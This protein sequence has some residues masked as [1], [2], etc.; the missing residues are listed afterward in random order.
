MSSKDMQ[1][2]TIWSKVVRSSRKVARSLLPGVTPPN[3]SSRAYVVLVAVKAISDK[4]CIAN[5]LQGK[6]CENEVSPKAVIQSIKLLYNITSDD[7]ELR[8]DLEQIAVN[9]ICTN[10]NMKK[11]HHS[12]APRIVEEWIAKA[13]SLAMLE[14]E[15][16]FK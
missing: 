3:F 1:S 7:D 5:T 9:C 12:Q 13:N 6:K 14:S 10:A 16:F 11:P 4:H 2:K 15:S 8:E